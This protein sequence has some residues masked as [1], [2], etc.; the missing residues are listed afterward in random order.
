MSEDMQVE[1]LVMRVSNLVAV[2]V[3]VKKI[4]NQLFKDCEEMD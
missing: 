2:R 4:N 3:Q 1:K